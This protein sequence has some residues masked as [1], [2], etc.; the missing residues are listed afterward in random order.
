MENYFRL[1]NYVTS[2]EGAVSH[3][4]FYHQPL[5]ITHHQIGDQVRFY[6]NDYFE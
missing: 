1:E 3:N 6:A 2:T 5:P 4:V